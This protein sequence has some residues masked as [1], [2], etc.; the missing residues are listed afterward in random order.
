MRE[1]CW[2]APQE[3]MSSRHSETAEE[4]QHLSTTP[5]KYEAS[6]QAILIGRILGAQF[7]RLV[8]KIDI[9]RMINCGA[10]PMMALA[11]SASSRFTNRRTPP[12]A[13][14][15]CHRQTAVWSLY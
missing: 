9:V 3:V 11:R 2:G 7:V 1:R 8:S 12:I 14:P 10:D 13:V 15:M 4:A 5:A 6:H